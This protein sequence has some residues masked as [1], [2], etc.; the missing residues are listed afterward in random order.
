MFD[1]GDGT[2]GDICFPE[3]SLGDGT[4]SDASDVVLNALSLRE[5]TLRVVSEENGA[6]ARFCAELCDLDILAKIVR[7]CM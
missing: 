1:L 5:G 3:V 7:K 2:R 4:F 6:E